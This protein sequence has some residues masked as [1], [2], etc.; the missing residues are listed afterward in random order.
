M[1]SLRLTPES[2]GPF[3]ALLLAVASVS[4]LLCLRNKT[5]QTHIL[6]IYFTLLASAS[7]SGFLLRSVLTAWITEVF[8]VRIFIIIATQT[9]L[10]QFSY[11]FQA[12]PG[13]RQVPR[14]VLVAAT[15]TLIVGIDIAVVV[16]GDGSPLLC[17]NL[18]L[19]ICLL[20]LTI[21]PPVV[22]L[23]RSVAASRHQLQGIKPSVKGQGLNERSSD[24]G[25]R[26]FGSLIARPIGSKAHALR[27]FSLLTCMPL[28]LIANGLLA[29]QGILPL[30][31]RDVIIAVFASVYIFGFVSHYL[32]HAQERSSVHLKLVGL[33][34]VTALLLLQV[35]NS[36]L[37][38]PKKLAWEAGIRPLN[39]HSIH[40][41]MLENASYSI[42]HDTAPNALV[43][44]SESAVV[45]SDAKSVD[46]GFDFPFYDRTWRSVTLAETGFLL[47]GSP[48][49]REP[50]LLA[51]AFMAL[52]DSY[53]GAPKIM[54]LYA[55]LRAA[56]DLD[57]KI[58]YQNT[59]S[60]ATFTWHNVAQR[61]TGRRST[62]AVRLHRDGSIDFVYQDIGVAPDSGI[63][64]LTPGGERPTMVALRP[65]ATNT[66]DSPAGSGIVENMTLRYR[67]YAHKQV[68]SLAVLVLVTAMSI[69]VGFPF[70]Y[71]LVLTQPMQQLL[72]GL[73]QVDQGMLGTE[74]E[75]KTHDELGGFA[76]H[77]N[78]MTASLRSKEHALKQHAV[79]L[80]QAVVQRTAELAAQNLLLAEQSKRLQEIDS[81][82]SRFFADLSHEF[83]T[84][85][86]LTIGPLEDLCAGLHGPQ[87][88]QVQQ[89]LHIAIRNAR[90]AMRLINQILDIAK[91]EA[92]QLSLQLERI[93]LGQF[94]SD[95]GLAFVPLAERKQIQF[96][97]NMPVTR[98]WLEC[99][100]GQ[101]EK[102]FTNLL[103]NA[104]KYTAQAG[105]ISLS[106]QHLGQ[107]H[108]GPT[109][110]FKASIIVTVRDNGPG[111]TPQ[112]LPHVFERFYQADGTTP[113][114]QVGSGIGLALA[115]E[116]VELHQGQLTVTSE[117]GF[118]TSFTVR[119]AASE[120]IAS[121]VSESS[122]LPDEALA[123]RFQ[124]VEHIVSDASSE[125]VIEHSQD[126]DET[127]P[128]RTRILV[129][130]DNVEIRA[131]I[132]K[133]LTKHYQV[134]EAQDGA[135]ALKMAASL[136]PDL[137]V[138]DVM[139]PNMDGLALCRAVKHDPELD[140]MPVILLTAK[141]GEQDKLDG[142]GLGA[143]DYLCK[144]FSMAELS[145]R[146]DNLIKSRRRLKAHYSRPVELATSHVQVDSADQI[147][148]KR[149]QAVIEKQLG[150]PEFS[151]EYLAQAIGQSRG[152]L[153]RRLRRLLGQTPTDVIRNIRLQRSVDLLS[154][155]AGSISEIAYTVGFKAVAHF[156]TSFRNKYGVPPSAYRAKV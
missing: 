74:I 54:P 55:G 26:G 149:L 97:I 23:S 124:E 72:I 22:F 9:A 18:L 17:L 95:L 6:I 96:D 75:I 103:S 10:L 130:D 120:P 38:T 92:E 147:F 53:S 46:L 133:H 27:G 128:D 105:A 83:R 101:L 80:E 138:S 114:L 82:K 36:V 107:Q 99:D 1:D 29:V 111:I 125:S 116:L 44:V 113:S 58:S 50:G 25:L 13:R 145:A 52:E 16:V 64:G 34:L 12:S 3:I 63:I 142:L 84:P 119:L 151:V 86:T 88:P 153:H 8:L 109:T 2:I 148:L 123:S 62:F 59:P 112:Q 28:L 155:R 94:L 70:F 93:E 104:F 47:F 32:N 102:V 136:L 106:L 144:P 71:R 118:G 91:I 65:L 4:Y 39:G 37:Y 69:I 61:H 31:M 48:P 11:M 129:V 76:A 51:T 115:K 90:A 150:D 146:I 110:Q 45:L 134:I 67:N 156:S 5:H 98:V 60:S 152:N 33:S 43:M 15:L 122:R 137:M 87:S 20:A 68:T 141:A 89:Q 154:Q 24:V 132:R 40:F 127:K 77:F 143:D 21:A 121:A 14:L 56:A 117:V 100:P 79:Q 85:L 66:F 126:V 42:H 73:R 57:A 19:P 41:V 139:M 78:R 81:I 135:I 131:Y 35:V 30:P 49:H 7:L 108:L 140:Y